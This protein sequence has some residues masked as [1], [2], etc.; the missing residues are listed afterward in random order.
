MLLKDGKHKTILRSISQKG[1]FIEFEKELAVDQVVQIGWK[2]NRIGYIKGAFSITIKKKS[3]E[4]H[5]WFYHAR[6]FHMDEES[7]K[8]TLELLNLLNK[9]RS[10]AGNADLSQLQKIFQ[11]DTSIFQAF[12]HNQPLPVHVIDILKDI[13]EDEMQIHLNAHSKL[14]KSFQ[15][16]QVFYIQSS[17]LVHF[18]E[19][20]EQLRSKDLIYCFDYGLY[21]LHEIAVLEQN[22]GFAEPQ[23]SS[24]D[25]E[26]SMEEELRKIL[27]KP[28]VILSNQIYESLYALRI[29]CEDKQWSNKVSSNQ[30][31]DIGALHTKSMEIISVFESKYEISY[32]EQ[33][34]REAVLD[35][36]Y[37]KSVEKKLDR[38]LVPE[39]VPF[40][41][42]KKVNVA[43]YL[44]PVLAAF[45]AFQLFSIFN[46]PKDVQKKF[47]EKLVFPI[48]SE[49]IFTKGSNIMV[50]FNPNLWEGLE[51]FDR[52]KIKLVSSE[53]LAKQNRFQTVFVFSDSKKAEFMVMR[54]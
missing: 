52:E 37:E 36:I 12:Q 30:N 45:L 25:E 23:H 35:R 16:L 10:S 41:D 2:D 42:F 18:L 27:N 44:M 11:M 28:I 4:D 6:Y 54:E 22:S 47:K 24:G 48:A 50:F 19:T 40:D 34:Y 5:L 31:D 29:Y 26:K 1:I 49:K 14:E 46:G 51:P 9:P 39:D 43:K 53:Y 15:K 33:S 17:L 20:A 21:L 8:N 7:K 32:D 38:D 3:N 13:S